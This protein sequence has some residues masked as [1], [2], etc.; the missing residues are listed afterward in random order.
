MYN[1]TSIVTARYIGTKKPAILCL[2]TLWNGDFYRN[3]QVVIMMPNIH[4]Q[5]RS[6]LRQQHEGSL[7]TSVCSIA[8]F[9]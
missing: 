4:V 8:M 1:A 3:G 9:M 5:S 2:L 7:L 6:D